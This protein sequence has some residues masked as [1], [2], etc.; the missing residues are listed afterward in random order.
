[1]TTIMSKIPNPIAIAIAMSTVVL[2]E[3]AAFEEPSVNLGASS[4]FDGM[5]SI[6]S[7]Q[8][9]PG[10][11][12]NQYL[13]WYAAHRFNDPHGNRI[14][15]DLRL[16]AYSSLTQLIYLMP[17]PHILGGRIGFDA[18]LPI[19][20]LD[21]RSQSPFL[22]ANPAHMGDLTLGVALQFDPV[23][24]G[25]TTN[26]F[27]MHR[28]DFDIIV[29]SGDYDRRYSFNPGANF[30][31]L[32]PYWAGTLFL[33]SKAVTSWRIHYLYNDSNAQPSLALYPPGTEQVQ[34]GQAFHANFDFAYALYSHELYIGVNGYLFQQ[35]SDSQIN[36][37]P[38]RDS[39]E[40][41]ATIGPGIVYNISQNA[42]LTANL[43]FEFATVN[44][45]Q[46]T[47][48]NTQFAYHF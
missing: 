37:R 39:E 36:H 18:L 6:A 26:L 48:L 7:D 13:Q 9:D 32:N 40:R 47:R 15:G 8:A 25:S 42:H 5:C 21:V 43:Y 33:G 29:P 38:L 27:F 14:P 19:A 41:A 31:S 1:M 44:R 24:Y 17:Q 12:F 28:V 35:I 34:G 16:D 22:R 30:Y 20:E 46:G 2:D 45:P 3:A 23:N 4:F 10:L 11:Y